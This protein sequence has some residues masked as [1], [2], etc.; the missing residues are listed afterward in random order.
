MPHGSGRPRSSSSC[1]MPAHPRSSAELR[2]A[3]IVFDDGAMQALRFDP[4]LATSVA[5]S[6]VLALGP[7]L[8][9]T[10]AETKGVR[11]FARC[12]PVHSVL[13]GRC[14]IEHA[15]G[16]HTLSSLAV[17]A[18]TPHRVLALAGPYAGVAYLDARRYRFEDAQRLAH[19]W[20]GFEPGRDDLREAFGD[21][22]KL[23]RR[24][25]DARLLRAL[26]ALDGER[27]SVAQAALRVGL[28]ESRLTHLMTDTL[29]A[30]PRTWR[31]WFKLQRAV[32]ETLFNHKN[33][34]QAAHQ[35]GFADSAHLTR[36]CKQL[37]GVRPA[38]MMPRAVFVSSEG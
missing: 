31:A 23:A 6:P 2:R 36:T 3:E 21:A 33:L 29:G 25:V 9:L 15:G 7:H 17:P 4:P 5:S 26:E 28:S 27:L 19:A 34:T 8:A 32:G 16:V 10:T 22:L 12:P 13:L 1:S 30:P 18:N 20:R 11:L 35:A 38:Q 24:R 37:T 14:T